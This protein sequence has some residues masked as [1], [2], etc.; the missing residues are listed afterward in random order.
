MFA[1]FSGRNGIAKNTLSTLISVASSPG[2]VVY[3]HWLNLEPPQNTFHAWFP[4]YLA[5]ICFPTHFPQA[6]RQK[7]EWDLFEHHHRNTTPPTSIHSESMG[8]FSRSSFI[9]SVLIFALSKLKSAP[10]VS[11]PKLLR[12]KTV[13]SYDCG[14]KDWSQTMAL[15]KFI[16]TSLY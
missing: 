8:I 4:C 15:F 7:D 9:A 5:F 14:P 10:Q 16:Q 11:S 1:I 2:L 3:S 6:Q 12:Y 13:M